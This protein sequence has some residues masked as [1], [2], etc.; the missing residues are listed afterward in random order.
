LELLLCYFVSMDVEL[1]C[2][3]GSW[4]YLL[5][6]IADLLVEHIHNMESDCK[7]LELSF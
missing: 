7:L 6:V 1:C 3:L 5:K 2:F 4:L